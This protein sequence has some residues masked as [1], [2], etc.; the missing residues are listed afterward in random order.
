MFV[1]SNEVTVFAQPQ[2]KTSGHVTRSK[3]ASTVTN[4]HTGIRTRAAWVKTRNPNR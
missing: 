1:L 4:S 2:N 3:N